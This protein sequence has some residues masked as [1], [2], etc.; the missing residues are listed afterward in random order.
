MPSIPRSDTGQA[1]R[2]GGV[3]A[4]EA[5]G[6]DP[7][8]GSVW[9]TGTSGAPR[10]SVPDPAGAGTLEF[11][12]GDFVRALGC[13]VALLCEVDGDGS[14]QVVC[15][16]GIDRPVAITISS[17]GGTRR[18]G[19]RWQHGGCFV[20]RALTHERPAFET[21]NRDRDADLLCAADAEL[22]CA[23][24]APV[25]LFGRRSGRVLIGGFS[26]PP[27]NLDRAFWVADLY[28][29]LVALLGED[30][31]AL[32][33]LLGHPRL[34]ALTGCLAYESVL[35]ELSREI[36]RSARAGL[37]LSCCF[38]DLDGFK[39]VN[40][41]Y[42]HLRGNELLTDI[43]GAL[44]AGV[45]SCDTVGRYGGD[46]FIAL[47]PQTGESEAALLA[48]RLHALIASGCM[49]GLEEQLTASIGVAEWSHGLSG[50]QLLARADRALFAA[51]A[52]PGGVATHS[53]ASPEPAN[54]RVL[55]R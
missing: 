11:L 5:S 46:E 30:A 50:E 44:R 12:V 20:G 31:D 42:G 34:D 8:N 37:T 52:L 23:L 6:N 32:G 27:D 3:W 16:S 19:N 4:S 24:A 48:G 39:R 43:G 9:A 33:G 2:A 14:G 53:Q 36:N 28:A 55:A 45:R 1:L 18:S 41:V 54:G 7:E 15:A 17:R 38:I 35:G 26:A 22:T 10:S 29:R 21:L 49:E 40:D 47:L 13:E 25:Q 51:K